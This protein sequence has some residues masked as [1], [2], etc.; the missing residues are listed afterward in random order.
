MKELIEII[1]RNLETRDSAGNMSF[2]DENGMMTEDAYLNFACR[3]FGKNLLVKEFKEALNTIDEVKLLTTAK[4]QQ[5]YPVIALLQERSGI[6][7]N[8]NFIGISEAKEKFLYSQEA[9]FNRIDEKIKSCVE[10]KRLDASQS[11]DFKT[12]LEAARDRFIPSLFVS[13]KEEPEVESRIEIKSDI[14]QLLEIFGEIKGATSASPE[15]DKEKTLDLLKKLQEEVK[16]DTATGRWIKQ[17]CREL[18]GKKATLGET[19]K[20]YAEIAGEN[21]MSFLALLL[22]AIFK[23]DFFK[24]NPAYGIS[25]DLKEKLTQLQ[26]DFNEVKGKF[27]QTLVA[28]RS[29]TTKAITL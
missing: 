7:A 16:N 27:S 10:Q 29:Q 24:K 11:K 28:D 13:Q 1:N 12:F 26:S 8:I 2:L 4:M 9:L 15:K 18:E 22:N 5:A 6:D 17:A 3:V 14:D 19:I 20:D 23:T 21:V 25:D